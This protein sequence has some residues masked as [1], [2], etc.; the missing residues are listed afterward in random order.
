MAVPAEST[1]R[2][3]PLSRSIR[4][5]RAIARATRDSLPGHVGDALRCVSCHLD[6]GTRA[7][8]M[9]WA[10][11]YGRFPQ[12]RSRSGK[13]QGLDDRIN[14]CL[15]R[16]MNGAPLARG[17]EDLRDVAAYI[18]WLSR[19]SVSGARQR[20]SGIDSIG[21]LPPDTS[22][23]RTSYLL[24]CARCHG[25]SGE[26]IAGTVVT[27]SGPPLWGPG[28][29][30]IGSGMA[31]V[32]VMAAFVHRN[33]PFDQPGT[34]DAQTAFDVAG[35]VT[36]HGRPDFRGKELDWPRGDAPPDAAYE[37]RAKKR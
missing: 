17:G 22:R 27:A 12:Y 31:R 9:P 8:A 33:M 5:G 35:F 34:V 7:Y 36:S 19:G 30:N 14:D 6:D 13:V 24:T 18:S 21:P 37:T 15:A 1:L 20:G 28:S 26:G 3:D 25:M 2:A 10:G 4:R 11:A 32:R 16:S 23:G 29:F